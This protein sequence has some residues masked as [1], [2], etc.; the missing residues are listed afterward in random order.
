[1]QRLK[2]R[3]PSTVHKAVF[4]DRDGRRRR[5]VIGTGLVLAL[6]L[7]AWLVV[8][9][10]GFAVVLSQRSSPVGSDVAA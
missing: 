6:A 4:V 9:G 2:P 1:M 7:V 3:T 5:A 10:V 8:M